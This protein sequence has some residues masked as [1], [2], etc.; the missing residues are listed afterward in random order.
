MRR[1]SACRLRLSRQ[2]S[3]PDQGLLIVKKSSACMPVDWQLSGKRDDCLSTPDSCRRHSRRRH[4]VR[5][6][7]TATRL[8]PVPTNFCGATG[9]V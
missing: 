3:T 1:L 5:R 8:P 7:L 9:V 4:T 6:L 2:L